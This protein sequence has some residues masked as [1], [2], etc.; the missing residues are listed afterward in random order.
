M[1]TAIIDLGT[2]TF[3]LMIVEKTGI[4]DYHILLET[5]YPAKL[6]KGGINDNTITPE[7]MER[8]MTALRTHLKTMEPFNVKDIKCIA[9]AA[10]RSASNGAAFVERVKTELG[11][12]IEV[13]DGQK[14]AQLIFDGVKQVMP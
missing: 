2:N 12:V 3:N 6:G 13:V 10:I 4:S 9:T 5:K 1:R 11:L 7:A 14:E 8:G